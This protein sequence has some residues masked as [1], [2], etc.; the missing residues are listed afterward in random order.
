MYLFSLYTIDKGEIVLNNIQPQ[1]GQQ[2]GFAPH[3]GYQQEVAPVISMKEWMIT[4]LIMIIPVVN[5][6]MMFVFAFGEGNP[7]KKNYFKA[8]LLFAAIILAIYILIMILFAGA[9]FSMLGNSY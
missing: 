4:L 7:S 8:S 9:L 3:P 6:I 1:Q 5:I 2:G